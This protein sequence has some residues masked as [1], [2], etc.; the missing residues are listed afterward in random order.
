MNNLECYEELLL[1]QENASGL[2]REQ[3]GQQ[4][5]RFRV[6]E[7]RSDGSAGIF[8]DQSLLGDL[9]K[10]VLNTVAVSIEA[11]GTAL[12]VLMAPLN[13]LKTLFV[14]MADAAFG[15]EGTEAIINSVA[16]AWTNIQLA[17]QDVLQ[18]VTA[19]ATVIGEELGGVIAPLVQNFQA[20]GQIQSFFQGF[21]DWLSKY[22]GALFDG[23]AKAFE[24]LIGAAKAHLALQPI[25]DGLSLLLIL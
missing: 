4:P 9:I 14:S 11:I 22:F 13:A 17:I 15:I 5:T 18:W 6:P 3:Q 19:F 10:G 24:A 1:N 7:T 25:V 23:L 21:G 20:F 12:Q 2:Q 16:D 8:A